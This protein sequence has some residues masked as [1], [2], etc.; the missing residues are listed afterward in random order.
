MIENKF[1]S[2]PFLR[3]V[4][5]EKR[6]VPGCRYNEKAIQKPKISKH[7]SL[8]LW[9]QSRHPGRRSILQPSDSVS[10]GFFHRLDIRGPLGNSLILSEQ[11]L[12]NKRIRGTNYQNQ[13][14]SFAGSHRQNASHVF[15]S[16]AAIRPLNFSG[17]ALNFLEK[18]YNS[19]LKKH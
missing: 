13:S 5:W 2:Q 3:H 7:L 10:S 19:L 6:F 11:S 9:C 12:T 1:R 15:S 14:N 8:P 17:T 16:L 18:N 4:P